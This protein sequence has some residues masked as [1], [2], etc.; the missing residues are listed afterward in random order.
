MS[1]LQFFVNGAMRYNLLSVEEEH[2]LTEEYARTRSVELRNKIVNHN[3]RLVMKV[4]NEFYPIKN[5]DLVGEGATGLIHG[6]ERFDPAK[7]YKLSTYVTFW[8]RAYILSYIVK[9]AR[10]VKVGTTDTQRKLFFNLK[11]EQAKL[12]A[13]GVEVTPELIAEKMGVPTKDV[14]E[15][16]TRLSSETSIDQTVGESEL[17]FV[18]SI[19][20][21]GLSPE[22]AL[23][24]A[25]S[26]SLLKSHFEVFRNSLKPKEKVVFDSRIMEDERLREVGD[27]LNMCRER[28]RQIEVMVKDKFR[29]FCDLKSIQA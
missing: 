28:V 6:V 14:V 7:G 1:T 22:E 29:R 8:I 2:E 9:D 3:L 25:E 23:A 11:K 19:A 21:E 17:K 13:S 16:Q 24:E 10:L 20:S 26:T 12:E 4:A 15:M 5:A 27:K 18:D